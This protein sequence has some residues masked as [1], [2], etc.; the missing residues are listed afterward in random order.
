IPNREVKPACADGTAIPSGR[1]G[2]RHLLQESDDL[3]IIRLFFFVPYIRQSERS[4]RGE[5]NPQL[6]E[7]TEEKKFNMDEQFI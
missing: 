4:E 5:K 2:S 6:Q 1:V 7:A 3:I